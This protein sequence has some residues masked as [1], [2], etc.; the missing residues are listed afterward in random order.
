MVNNDREDTIV[1]E[2]IGNLHYSP[3]YCHIRLGV[4]GKLII[5]LSLERL[6]IGHGSEPMAHGQWGPAQPAQERGGP[7]PGPGK[8]PLASGLVHLGHEP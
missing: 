5:D 3:N 2:T 7:G 8:A 6:F 4:F 1:I